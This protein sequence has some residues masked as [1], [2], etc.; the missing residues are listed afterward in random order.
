MLPAVS[1]DASSAARNFSANLKNALPTPKIVISPAQEDDP[2][3]GFSQDGSEDEM[4]Q[5][6][7]AALESS[8]L[9]VQWPPWLN[10][11]ASVLFCL[12]LIAFA[13]SSL[14]ALEQLMVSRDRQSHGI[15]SSRHS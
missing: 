5:T 4:R 2:E 10:K 13:A 15:P 3:S 9:A 8:N 7:G 14:V 12:G 11:A 6:L 1:E